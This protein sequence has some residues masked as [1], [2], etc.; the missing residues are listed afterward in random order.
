[1]ARVAGLE[2]QIGGFVGQPQVVGRVFGDV[3][4]HPA[5]GVRAVQ[6]RGRTSNDFNALERVQIHCVA[7][8][9]IEQAGTELEFVR[10]TH[11]VYLDQHAVAVDTANVVAGVA[12]APL[13]FAT[14]RDIGLVADQVIDVLRLGA[15][16][17]FRRQYG[18]G[19]RHIVDVTLGARRRDGDFL[20]LFR[21]GLL[22]A[23]GMRRANGDSQNGAMQAT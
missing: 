12:K 20:E 6:R 13:R 11:A 7:P 10:Q 1:M 8:G 22:C 14:H 9:A 3:R 4:D 17:V 21:C 18:N 23:G 2:T 19:V 16:D 15:L 5:N